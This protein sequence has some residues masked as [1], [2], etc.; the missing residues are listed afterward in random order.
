[1]AEGSEQV[2]VRFFGALHA[3]RSKAGLPTT[4]VVD[5]PAE[6]VRA[7]ELAL[8]LGLP[9]DAIEGVFCNGDV[10]GLSRILRPGD[11]V[12]FVPYGT[13]GPHRFFLGL[14]KAGQ[15]DDE[16]TCD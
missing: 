16:D 6:G 1:M 15:E 4:T 10:F 12:A 9:V 8:G 13:P 14:Y 7:R 11:R 2:T 3:L 5:V